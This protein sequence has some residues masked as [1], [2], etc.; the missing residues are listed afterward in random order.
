MTF[1]SEQL[2]IL[3]L[4][5][6]EIS[7][8]LNL[9]SISPTFHNG[10]HNQSHWYPSFHLLESHHHFKNSALLQSPLHPPP[11]YWSHGKAWVNTIVAKLRA[12]HSHCLQ[13][14]CCLA[15]LE[16][17]KHFAT[18]YHHLCLSPVIPV[19][20][21]SYLILLLFF[22]LVTYQYNTVQYNTN[23][24]SIQ[25]LHCLLKCELGHINLLLG[26]ENNQ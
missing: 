3:H 9:C 4:M 15:F 24:L 26:N 14:N 10:S 2:Y 17:W 13:E 1:L 5:G 6:A 16:L 18:K 11:M 8:I 22:N 23:L 19:Y 7:G 12:F 20:R 21:N 25:Q